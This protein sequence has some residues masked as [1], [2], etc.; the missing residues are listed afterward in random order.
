MINYD[1]LKIIYKNGFEQ[2]KKD[3]LYLKETKEKSYNSLGEE[4]NNMHDLTVLCYKCHEKFH[5][6]GTIYAQKK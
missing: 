2:Y 4:F 5:K 3:Y 1:N 6:K